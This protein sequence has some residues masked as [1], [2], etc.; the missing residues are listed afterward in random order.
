MLGQ[1]MPTVCHQA[2]KDSLFPLSL[3]ALRYEKAWGN[4][5]DKWEGVSQVLGLHVP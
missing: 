1:D 5:C 4:F 3:W 2:R